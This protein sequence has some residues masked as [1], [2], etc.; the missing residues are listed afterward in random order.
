MFEEAIGCPERLV[1]QVPS[2]FCAPDTCVAGDH[3]EIGPRGV[4]SEQ[5]C[6]GF[7]TSEPPGPST[8]FLD[9]EHLP[10]VRRALEAQIE[11]IHRAEQALEDRGSDK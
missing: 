7:A 4:P 5:P 10:A 1:C 3:S 2:F 11:E 9:A 8:L 6:V